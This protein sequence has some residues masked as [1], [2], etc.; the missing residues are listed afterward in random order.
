MAFSHGSSFREALC[1][2]RR[3]GR[4][5]VF[6]DIK[7]QR[8]E[9]P[10]ADFF[11][12][13]EGSNGGGRPITVW[14]S[15]DYLNM[16]QHPKVLAAMHEALDSV[17][18]GSGGTRNISGTSHYHVELERELAD[19]HG[20]E[21]ALLFTSGFVSN[22]ATL[23]TLAKILP[24]LIIFSDEFNHASMIEGIRHGGTVKYVFRHNDMAHLEELLKAA[25]P[26]S[27]KLIAFEG[28]Y[29]MDG[30]LCAHRGDLRSG[31]EIRR[32]DL[33]RRSSWRGALRLQRGRGGRPRRHHGPHRHRRR[34][35]G[36]GL[37]GD[38]RLY[39]HL[40]RDRGLHP[41]LRAGLYLH[42]LV[43]AG[44]WRPGVLASIRHLKDSDVE[45][46]RLH[47][48]AARLKRRLAEARH[49]GDG[50]PQPY[51]AGV[52]GRCHAVQEQ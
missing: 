16:G 51:R 5:R 24:G 33:Y 17:G 25:N 22:D 38:G 31:R 41:L 48:R 21:A 44:A 7:R 46:E 27:P 34:H 1:A 8:G 9:Y 20:K 43:G 29:S 2:L 3:E 18:A 14:C 50:K 35:A 37:R 47:D 39:R 4:Y 19:L 49:S 28:V 40:L 11:T 26:T 13:E 10:K 15:N 52:R 45:R 12:D 36:Q 30:R 23:A 42:H 32:P 6:A